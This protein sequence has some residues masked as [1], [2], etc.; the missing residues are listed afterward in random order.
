MT[1]NGGR[2]QELLYGHPKGHM[3][4]RESSAEDAII[5]DRHYLT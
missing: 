3:N 1:L 5:V 4:W 2:H